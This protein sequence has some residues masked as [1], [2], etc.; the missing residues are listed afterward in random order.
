MG[1]YKYKKVAKGLARYNTIEVEDSP[2]E[3][4]ERE[5]AQLK[6]EGQLAGWTADMLRD[7]EERV[8]NA[9]AKSLT[10]AKSVDQ[11]GST[12]K[13]QAA[14]EDFKKAV[15]MGKHTFEAMPLALAICCA[16]LIVVVPGVGAL[17][18]GLTI[19]IFHMPDERD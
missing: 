12:G 18:L 15:F 8:R 3:K 16:L 4:L 11:N 19:G 6:V 14:K 17:G 13:I 7:Q 9:S 5:L 1:H 2:E 10:S